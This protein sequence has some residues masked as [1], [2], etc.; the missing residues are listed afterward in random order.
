MKLTIPEL[1]L[2]V[3]MGPSGAGKST[4]ARKHFLPT[5]IVSSDECRGIVA[6]NP[7]SLEATNDAFD[8]L[9]YIAG[10]RLARGRLTVIDATNVQ[11]E[12]RA[13]LLKLAREHDVLCA[14]VVLK[15][16]EEVCRERNK[17]RRDRDFG[18][19]VIRNQCL[20]LRRSIRGLRREG[21]RYQYVLS[22]P[23]EIESVTFERQ[24]L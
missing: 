19:H 9:N 22:S 3:L 15:L 23:E 17:S 14:A 2:V 8:V 20:Q 11:P 5:E 18:S 12:A 7:N 13:P 6:D 21:F 1:C 24:P 16:P 10:K 4:F